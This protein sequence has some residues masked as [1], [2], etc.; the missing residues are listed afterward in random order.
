MSN[1]NSCQCGS[2]G[3]EKID[4]Y[5]TKQCACCLTDNQGV[6]GKNR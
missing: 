1:N 5:Y 6:F 3:H 2:C 4:E